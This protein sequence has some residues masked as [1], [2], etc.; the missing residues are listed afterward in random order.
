M[1]TYKGSHG[2]SKN[3]VH[4][5]WKKG[6]IHKRGRGGT[7]VYFWLESRYYIKLAIGW[8]RFSK[9]KGWFSENNPKCAVIIAEMKA[10]E[11]EILDFQDD[12]L[13]DKIINLA[14]QKG[15]DLK[16]KRN[17]SGLYDL[18]IKESEKELKTVFKIILLKAAPPPEDCCPDYP[19]MIMGAP[20]CCSVRDNSCIEIK[21]IRIIEDDENER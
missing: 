6:F 17:L 18:F 19:I 14:E 3:N 10:E 15:I 4:N 12:V 9:S 21:N 20:L 8:F 13:K 16:N 1:I 2:T 7:G 11:R 5:I